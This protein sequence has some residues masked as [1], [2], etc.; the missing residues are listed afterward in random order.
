MDRGLP[1]QLDELWHPSALDADLDD[2]SLFRAPDFGLEPLQVENETDEPLIADLDLRPSDIHTDDLDDHE[3]AQRTVELSQDRLTDH[4]HDSRTLVINPAFDPSVFDL[5]PSDGTASSG[6]ITWEAFGR[7]EVSET[8]VTGCLSEAKLEAFDAA[9]SLSHGCSGV[10]PQDTSLRALCNLAL[11]RS[12]VFFQWDATKKSFAQTIP[13]VPTS[14]LSL[15]CYANL[16]SRLM[17]FGNMYRTL[18]DWADST[19]PLRPMR[20][21]VR[22]LQRTT[23]RILQTVEASIALSFSDDLHSILQL[24][25]SISLPLQLLD[26]LCDLKEAVATCTTEEQAISSI[27]HQT[28]AIVETGSLFADVLRLL[29]EEI[30]APW[31]EGLSVELGLS[32]VCLHDGSVLDLQTSGT[33]DQ[34]DVSFHAT[35]PAQLL[36]STLLDPRDQALIR[37]TKASLRLVRLHTPEVR[38]RCPGL[39]AANFVFSSNALSHI[40]E[41]TDKHDQATEMDEFFVLNDMGTHPQVVHPR[42]QDALGET[43]QATLHTEISGVVARGIKLES[44]VTQTIFEKLRPAVTM[45]ARYLN[46]EVLRHIFGTC[47]LKK[48]LELQRSFHLFGNGDFVIRLSTALFSPDTQTARRTRGVIPTGEALGLRLST[49]DGQPWPP[50]S[51]ELRLTLNEVMDDCNQDLQP[52]RSG[53]PAE[54]PGNLS[55]SI[56]ELSDEEIDRVMDVSSIYALDFLRLQ[57]TAPAPL[58]TIITPA[59]LKRYDDIFRFLLKLLRVLDVT[60]RLRREH[61]TNKTPVSSK[62]KRFALAAHHFTSNLISTMMDLGI[63]A[64]WREFQKGIEEVEQSVEPRHHSSLAGGLDAGVAALRQMHEVCLEGIRSHL[65]LKRKQ[66]KV[67]NV[68]HGVLDTILQACSRLHN[69]SSRFDDSDFRRALSGALTLLQTI[70]HMPPKQH[71]SQIYEVEM[72]RILLARLNFNEVAY[73]GDS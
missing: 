47:G 17:G 45:Q 15:P 52:R 22:V 73:L 43:V 72:V 65:F 14:G 19:Q 41:M 56:R 62:A 63:E 1:F 16:L 36:A 57:Y 49:R 39:D 3:L 35:S 13:D 25:Q 59:S 60:T 26:H 58:D 68:I 18:Q 55:F 34:L 23:L 5:H 2:A 44:S 48:H 40:A 67:S 6:L 7:A 37:D 51:S 42:S 28:Q 12:S 24:Q 8:A 53:T 27:S 50:A 69:A 30:C 33:V 9:L 54:L 31:L 64:P 29:L 20:P 70:V 66:A 11:G 32:D 71:E 38:L 21:A 61:L 10:L 46:Q 4:S